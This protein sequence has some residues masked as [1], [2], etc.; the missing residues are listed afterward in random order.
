MVNDFAFDAAARRPDAHAAGA[1]LPPVGVDAEPARA[2]TKGGFADLAQV[3]AWNQEFVAASPEGRTLRGAG[4]RDR[5]G[6]AVHG[7][8]RHRPRRRAP[9]A[10]GR[11]LDLARG[12]AARLRGG[13]HPARQHHRRLV[14]LLGAPALDRRPDP[15]AR[16]RARRVPL[17]GA[18]PARRE[19][20][21]DADAD[22]VVALCKRLNPDANPGRLVL[23]RRMGADRVAESLPPLLRRGRDVRPPRR[24]GLRPDA[25]QHVPALQRLQDPPTSTT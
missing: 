22:D 25:R 24:L 14:R 20:R 5:A 6:A 21:P 17:R 3:H 16:R 1:R 23:F 2:F 9:A 18:Q 11:L 7:R 10:P 19:A 12:A 8:V 13:A 4:R 15:P